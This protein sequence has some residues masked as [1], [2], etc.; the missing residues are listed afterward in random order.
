[1]N[2]EIKNALFTGA[3]NKESLYDLS[4]PSK[5]NGKLVIFIHGYM[6]Y[7]DWG[8]WNL[9]QGFFTKNQFGFIKYNASH[10]GSTIENPIDFDDLASFGQNN[11]VKELQDFEAITNLVQDEFDEMPEIYVIGH[12]RGGGISLLQSS[13]GLVS[14]IVSWA[15][16]SSISDRFPKGKDLKEW[17]EH[18]YY[19]RKNGRTGQTM[20]HSYSQYESFLNYEQRLNIENYCKNSTTP[21]LVIHGENDTSVPLQEG[22]HIASWLETKLK[23]I[24][25]TQH[26]FDSYQPWGKSEMPTALTQVCQLTLDFFK[27]TEGKA[28]SERDE[29]LSLLADLVKLAKSDN[30]VREIEFQFLFSIAAQL[31]ITKDDFMYVFEKNIEFTPPKLEA[32]RIVQFQRL[33]LLMNVDLEAGTE[34]IDYIKNIGMRMGLNPMAT[35]E[36]LNRMNDH[37]NKIVP[38]D[39]LLVIFKTFNN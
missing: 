10:N 17:Q 21:T 22:E 36:V 5:W 25:G 18:G 9:V 33:I 7:K 23:I 20:P 31:G 38:P 19:Y 37:E 2:K 3:N 32:D 12:S 11:Y 16:I 15:G 26:T 29:K 4:I 6:G 27:G 35:N 8:C 1:M 14:K 39:E 24:P 13:N 34:E 28:T 30:E